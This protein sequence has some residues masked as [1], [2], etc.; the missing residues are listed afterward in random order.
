MQG[1]PRL[2]IPYRLITKL[3]GWKAWVTEYLLSLLHFNEPK[4]GILIFVS[5]F[6]DEHSEVLDYCKYGQ[7]FS[8]SVSARK[9]FFAL[10]I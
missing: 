3:A 5:H 10:D 4:G 6:S 7:Y 9:D 1:K 2:R 8:H